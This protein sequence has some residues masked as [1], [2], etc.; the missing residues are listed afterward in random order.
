[1]SS[2]AAFQCAEAAPFGQAASAE[3]AAAA[4]AAPAAAAAG[5]AAPA[6]ALSGSSLLGWLYKLLAFWVQE[7]LYKLDP[8]NGRAFGEY[9]GNTFVDFVGSMKAVGHALE[10][11]QADPT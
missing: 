10:L 2:F 9:M 8:C 4:A 1:M 3:P 5:A 11:L 7:H 6:Q